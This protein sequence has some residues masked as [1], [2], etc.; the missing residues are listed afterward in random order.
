MPVR[1]SPHTYRCTGCGWTKTVAPR[2]DVLK[3][4]DHFHACPRCGSS[5]L[6]R[7]KAPAPAVWLADIARRLGR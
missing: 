1:P 7:E 6:K 4:G 2:S 5:E 3:P